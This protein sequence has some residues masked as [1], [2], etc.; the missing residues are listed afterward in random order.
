MDEDFE[1]RPGQCVGRFAFFGDD[2]NLILCATTISH[3]LNQ[4]VEAALRFHYEPATRT[5]PFG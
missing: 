3:Q 2:A 4:A 5:N 1:K